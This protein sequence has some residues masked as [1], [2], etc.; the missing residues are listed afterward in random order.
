MHDQ[1]EFL[2]G[3]PSEE[4][5]W[6]IFAL[7]PFASFFGLLNQTTHQKRFWL[8][9]PLQTYRIWFMALINLKGFVVQ[10][11]CCSMLPFNLIDRSRMEG[12]IFR[13]PCCLYPNFQKE[14]NTDM[15]WNLFPGCR[16]W[17][18]QSDFSFSKPVFPRTKR[19]LNITQSW[20][21]RCSSVELL[22]P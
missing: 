6:D 18:N 22:T 14:G 9:N 5:I 2:H 16:A 20:T 3:F 19:R 17:T 13:L 10:I 21:P 15:T 8:I 7:H 12:F 4:A 11:Q 1:L